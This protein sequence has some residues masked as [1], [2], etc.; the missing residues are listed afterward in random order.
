MDPVEGRIYGAGKSAHYVA[1][2]LFSCL[3]RSVHNTRIERLWYDV[4]SGFGQKWN[5]FFYDLEMHC[6][7][8]P[9]S[10]WHIWLL[11]YLF[12]SAINDDAAE[13]VMMWNNH[14][15]QLRG[16]SVYLMQTLYALICF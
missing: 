13:W 3:S 2:F 7:L 6:S 14:T 15:M 11:H 9:D 16:A 8:N 4:T 12:L 5:N 1:V 10:A